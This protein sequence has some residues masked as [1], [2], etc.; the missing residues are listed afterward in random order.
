MP[1]KTIYSKPVTLAETIERGSGDK[2][3]KIEEVKIRKPNSG[4]LRGLK[5]AQIMQMDVDTMMVL[6]PR[7]TEPVLNEA[8]IATLDPSDFTDLSV[9]VVNFFDN[10]AKSQ[11]G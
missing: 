10:T 2:K 3:Q 1:N 7:V 6:L 11:V 4:E 9:E 5:I 8:D